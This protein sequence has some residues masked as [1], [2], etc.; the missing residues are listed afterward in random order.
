M[1][2][3]PMISSLCEPWWNEGRIS[4]GFCGV[5]RTLGEGPKQAQLMGAE[6][7]FDPAPFIR[8]MEEGTD[9]EVVSLV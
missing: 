8:L 5:M 4:W 9:V 6:T 1:Q 7:L 2:C 3:L